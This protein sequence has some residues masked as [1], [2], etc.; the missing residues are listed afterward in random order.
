MY[1]N[2][3]WNQ[4][5]VLNNTKKNDFDNVSI[6][7]SGNILCESGSGGGGPKYEERKFSQTDRCHNECATRLRY[8]GSP[9]GRIHLFTARWV[10]CC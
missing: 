8:T 10:F 5:H 3:L 1:L 2:I 9:A 7:V 6:L 4:N